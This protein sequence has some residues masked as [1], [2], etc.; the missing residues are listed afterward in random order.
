LLS[1]KSVQHKVSLKH[2]PTQEV[3]QEWL[4]NEDHLV[5]IVDASGKVQFVN[6]PWCKAMECSKS[7]AEK[8]NLFRIL[9]GHLHNYFREIVMTG[10]SSNAI[11]HIALVLQKRQEKRVFLQGFARVEQRQGVTLLEA[12]LEEGAVKEEYDHLLDLNEREFRYIV[13]TARDIVCRTDFQGNM[14]YVNQATADITGYDMEEL[15]GMNYL[16]LI[17]DDERERVVAH[18][19]D[20]FKRKLADSFFE[21]KIL[22]KNGQ[23]VWIEQNVKTIFSTLKEGYIDGYQLIARDITERKEREEEL[24]IAH[25]LISK[26]NEEITASI[27][28]AKVIQRAFLPKIEILKR[29]FPESFVFYKPRDIVSGDFYWFGEKN[30]CIIFA[31]GDCTGHG[32]PGA[33]MTMVGINQ[34][35]N[36]VNEKGITDPGEI[37]RMLDWS[38]R[39]AFNYNK[40]GSGVR[41]GMDMAICTYNKITKK[42]YYAGARRPLCHIDGDECKWITPIRKSIGEKLLNTQLRYTTRLVKPEGNDTFYMFSDGYVDQFGGEQG[43]KYTKHRLAKLLLDN[44]G[45]TMDEMETL[46]ESAFMEWKGDYSQ[47]DDVVVLGFRMPSD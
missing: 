11:Q 30:G 27:N 26:K 21:F 17:P 38:I 29:I 7:E 34:M 14:L 23:T 32:V 13:E 16:Q 24:R 6:T 31:V 3:F 2:K 44:R 28:Y 35:N 15:T 36:I 47:I 41:D 25:K 10:R 9:P 8:T 33:F 4:K 40:E 18:Y 37:L 42:L 1:L 43:R 5:L 45:A 46:M 20:H 22:K 19:F 12:V 39:N